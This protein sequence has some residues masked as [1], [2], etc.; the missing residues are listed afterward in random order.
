MSGQFGDGSAEPTTCHLSIEKSSHFCDLNPSV[1]N[2]GPGATSCGAG[3]TT[4]TG[5][6]RVMRTRPEHWL[7]EIVVWLPHRVARA[8]RAQASAKRRGSPAQFTRS[9]ANLTRYSPARFTRSPCSLRQDIPPLPIS[10]YTKAYP[11][12]S[13]GFDFLKRHNAKKLGDLR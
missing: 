13:S 10:L 12:Y 11:L 5:R 7:Q 9:P 2:C 1:T 8:Q 6:L 3:A 4:R